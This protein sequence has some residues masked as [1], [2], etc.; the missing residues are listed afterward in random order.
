MN[1]RITRELLG[2]TQEQFAERIH[3]STQ[4]VGGIERGDRPALLDYLKAVDRTFGTA[5]VKFYEELVRGEPTPIWLKSWLD[6][7]REASLLR[8]FELAVVPGPLQTEAYASALIESSSS[9]RA[10]EEA[11][12]TRLARELI[13][14]RDLKPAQLTAILDEGVLYRHIGGPDVMRGQLLH[15]MKSAERDNVSMYVVPVTAGAYIGLD[16][17]ISLATVHGR[18]VGFADGPLRD[19]AIEDVDRVDDLERRW[20]MIRRYTPSQEASL[21][22]IK[23]AADQWT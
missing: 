12:A 4:H 22:L 13:V 7:E 14:T 19:D 20:E 23:K 8:Y 17:S 15:L 11:I 9:G 3:Y 21:E 10:A 16:G 1:L 18:V 5:F 2:L 6:R